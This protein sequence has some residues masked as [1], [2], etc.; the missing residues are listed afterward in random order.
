MRSWAVMHE[1]QS[2]KSGLCA[3]PIAARQG[4]CS[5]IR[6]AYPKHDLSHACRVCLR[7]KYG[8]VRSEAPKLLICHLQKHWSRLCS[9]PQPVM[10]APL[11][12]WLYCN[13]PCGRDCK[14]WVL[15]RINWPDLVLPL[16]SIPIHFQQP[17]SNSTVLP[18]GGNICLYVIKCR[19]ICF[20]K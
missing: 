19:R 1:I 2:K 13:V 5:T 9:D 14:K 12:L 7:S 6:T 17:E 16:S 3:L 11:L 20:W 10:G 4:C 18:T 8:R 15:P